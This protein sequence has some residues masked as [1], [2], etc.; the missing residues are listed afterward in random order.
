MNLSKREQNMV[1]DALKRTRKITAK[2]V[3]DIEDHGLAALMLAKLDQLDE[4][5]AK[6]EA[7]PAAKKPLNK[8]WSDA[9]GCYVTVPE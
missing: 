3:N 8:Y 7:K 4:L 9:L 1:L 2:N 6:F 5:I